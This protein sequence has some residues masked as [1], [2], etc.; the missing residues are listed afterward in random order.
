[1]RRELR[2][3]REVL[4]ELT[5]GEAAA[6]VAG[7]SGQSCVGVCLTGIDQCLTRAWCTTLAPVCA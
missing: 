1:M 7:L 3:R 2:V 5:D 4:S 6:V